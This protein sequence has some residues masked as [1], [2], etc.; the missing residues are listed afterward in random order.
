MSSDFSN[1]AQYLSAVRSVVIKL[2]TQSLADKSGQLDGAFLSAI[3]SQVARLRQKGLGVTIVSSGAIGSGMRELKL[4][5]RPTDLATLQAVAAVGQR[6]LMDAWAT[7]FTPH[8]M[9]VAQILLTRDDVEDRTRFLNL[10]NTIHAVHELGGVPIINE[11]DTVSTDELVKITFGDNDILAAMVTHALR[12][13]LLVL[14]SVVDGLLDAA[15][16]PVRLVRSIDEARR[17]V[18][19]EKSSLGKGGM[20]SKLTAAKMVTEAGE[21]M[22]VADGRMERVLIRIVEGEEVGTLFAPAA[23]R[24]SSRSRWI[25]SV[26]PAGAVI[27]D[28]GAV[29][30]LLE[31][32]KSLL[33]AGVRSVEGE[34]ERGDIIAVKGPDG[35]AVARGLSNYDSHDITRI[36]GQKTSAVR[37]LLGDAAYEEVIHRNNLVVG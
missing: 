17:L 6:R 28:E 4:A 36:Q 37:S 16:R 30:A 14:L 31:K 26:R 22:V 13:N 33:P 3:A 19:S 2:G 24:L 25:G 35:R 34:F 15:G 7:A 20:D 9:C 23:R 21:T 27:V 32:H 1:R 11:N 8:S 29:R 18:R 5:K 12:A 10:R